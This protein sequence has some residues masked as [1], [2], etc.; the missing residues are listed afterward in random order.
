MHKKKRT[1]KTKDMRINRMHNYDQRLNEHIGE[2]FH[3][4]RQQPEIHRNIER[5]E[6]VKSEVESTLIK[7]N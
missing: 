6:I 3:D 4:E 7:L 1:N 5:P 2:P